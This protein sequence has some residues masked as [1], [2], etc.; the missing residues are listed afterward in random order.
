MDEPSLSA[1]DHGEQK[2]IIAFIVGI[3]VGVAAII[4]LVLFVLRKADLDPEDDGR[5]RLR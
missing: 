4:V 1:R 5:W 3:L 2:V